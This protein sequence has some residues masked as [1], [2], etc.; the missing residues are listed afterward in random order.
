MKNKQNY[1]ERQLYARGKAFKWALDT[2]LI[3]LIIW[4]VLCELNVC[5]AEPLG[6]LLI[7]MSPTF[8][9]FMVI[10]IVNDAYDPINSRPGMIVFTMMPLA[11]LGML[12]VYIKDAGALIEGGHITESGG[13]MAIYISWVIISA[14]YWTCYAKETKAEK[15]KPDRR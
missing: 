4:E 13:V 7:L 5:S 3:S 12:I 2:M 9:V 10:C 8:I 11:A 14:V 1:D 6:E 15:E